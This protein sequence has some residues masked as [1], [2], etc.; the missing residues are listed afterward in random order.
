MIRILVLLDSETWE[1]VSDRAVVVN[2]TDGELDGLSRGAPIRDIIA[3][4]GS[5]PIGPVLARDKA[6]G[7]I[8]DRYRVKGN[9]SAL[10]ALDALVALLEVADG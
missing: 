5:T 7:A 4:H 10:D 3:A 9:P 2:V 6:M 1:V 8:L